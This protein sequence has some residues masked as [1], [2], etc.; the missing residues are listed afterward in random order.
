MTAADTMDTVLAR[1]TGNLVLQFVRLK[2]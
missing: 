2:Y 1:P